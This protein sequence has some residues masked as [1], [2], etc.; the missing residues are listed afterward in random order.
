MLIGRWGILETFRLVNH[1]WCDRLAIQRTYTL[2]PQPAA[3]EGC[4]AGG[5]ISKYTANLTLDTGNKRDDKTTT[6]PYS[7]YV[8]VITRLDKIIESENANERGIRCRG[9]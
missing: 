1:G 9:E 5:L 3:I 8:N 4:A 2:R 7:T 6:I